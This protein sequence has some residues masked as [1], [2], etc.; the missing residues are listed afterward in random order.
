MLGGIIGACFKNLV[1]DFPQ[2]K[3]ELRPKNTAKSIIPSKVSYNYFNLHFNVI[4]FIDGYNEN[5][6]YKY[7]PGDYQY[8]TNSQIYYSDADVSIQ[9]LWTMACRCK[10]ISEFGSVS[11]NWEDNYICDIRELVVPEGI[12]EV[13]KYC[14]KD[15]DIKNLDIFRYLYFGLKGKRLR[16]GY[17]ELYNVKLEENKSD[18][19]IENYLE[20]KLNVNPDFFYK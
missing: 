17:G 3:F 10:K 9:K 14:F 8:K 13:F 1:A 4:T 18:D 15:V 6:F 5:Y 12:R 11:D 2:R 7:I 19:C 20:F 16:Q